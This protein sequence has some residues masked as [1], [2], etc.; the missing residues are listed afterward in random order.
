[1]RATMKTISLQ[2]YQWRHL[3]A[4]ITL[5]ISKLQW[6]SLA[7]IFFTRRQF[8]KLQIVILSER[9]I[10]LLV[11]FHMMPLYFII[12]YKR[13]SPT[14]FLMKPGLQRYLHAVS[15]VICTMTLQG[16]CVICKRITS[17]FCISRVQ[18]S[19]IICEKDYRYRHC[20]LQGM[21]YSLSYLCSYFPMKPGFHG[22]CKEYHMSLGGNDI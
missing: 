3:C 6:L 19:I 1:M 13:A 11:F 12:I 16:F 5:I 20:L 18:D 4:T 7:Y 21:R 14:V 8:A 17:A 15:H 9:F 2:C 10:T 22:F